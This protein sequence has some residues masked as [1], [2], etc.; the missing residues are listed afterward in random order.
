MATHNHE[1]RAALEEKRN[2]TEAARR[3]KGRKRNDH[4]TKVASKEQTIPKLTTKTKRADNTNERKKTD[5]ASGPQKNATKR[6]QGAHTDQ[7]PRKRAQTENYDAAARVRQH[8]RK[9]EGTNA[10]QRKKTKAAS[11]PQTIQKNASKRKRAAQTDESPRKKVQVKNDDA[12][13]RVRQQY[14]E[15][16]GMRKS[17]RIAG[18]PAESSGSPSAGQYVRVNDEDDAQVSDVEPTTTIDTPVTGNT[19]AADEPSDQDVRRIEQRPQD[20]REVFARTIGTHRIV[21]GMTKEY[22]SWTRRIH[23]LKHAKGGLVELE[24]RFR[25]MDRDMES[26]EE[27]KEAVRSLHAKR[28]GQI[29]RHQAYVDRLTTPLRA[30]IAMHTD[31]N[32]R[33][34]ES[35]GT[36]EDHSEL[37]FLPPEFWTAYKNCRTAYTACKDIKSKIHVMENERF[38]MIQQLDERMIAS[39]SRDDRISTREADEAQNAPFGE[40]TENQNLRIRKLGGRSQGL[41]QLQEILESARDKQYEEESRLNQIAE[42][43]FVAAGYLRAVD[44]PEEIE[45][46]RRVPSDVGQRNTGRRSNPTGPVE[47]NEGSSSRSPDKSALADKVRRARKNLQYH[48]K[49]LQDARWQPLSDA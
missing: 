46:H 22:T 31:R 39:V 18:Q 26:S 28:L 34:Y 43:A 7:P 10:D 6:K 48:R 25:D 49:R 8:Y 44:D 32:D 37:T 23:A 17:R 30:M 47:L 9:P 15:P 12:A 36:H 11:G 2:A 42:A 38:D 4:D 35:I 33:I 20:V 24:R 29:K 13:A 1:R 45:L 14:Q 3:E 5:A 16:E 40:S 41:Q 19:N 21:R 27:E